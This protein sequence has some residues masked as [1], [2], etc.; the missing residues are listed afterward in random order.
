M[1]IHID[2]SSIESYRQFLSIKKLPS[3]AISGR[4]ASFPDEYAGRIGASASPV[5]HSYSPEP[6]LFDYQSAIAE[7]AIRKRKFA[8]FADCGLGKSLILL[9]YA[10]HVS[11]SHGKRCL[12]LTP[13]MVVRQLESE[14]RRF[15]GDS[16]HVETVSASR[17][18]EW[19][20]TAGP[21]VGITNYE[22]LKKTTEPGELGCLILDESSILKSHYGNYASICIKL[23][24]GLDWKLCLTGTPAPNDRI[25]YANHGVFLD[26]FPTI[27]SFLATYFIN[28][29][30]TQERWALKP[31]ALRPFYR[32]LSD[33]CIFLTN[34]AVYGWIDN[35][36]TIPPIRTHIHRVE[37]TKQQRDWI[38]GHLGSLVATRAGGI[39]T[40]G[41]YGQVAKGHWKGTDFETNKPGAIADL[42]NSWHGESTL[43]WCIYDR[44]QDLVHDAI[45]GESLSGKT[46]TQQRVDA[47][48]RFKSG[49]S[50]VLISKPRILG[51]GLNLQVATR[52]VFSGLQD[53]Y[54]SYYQCVKRSNRVGSTKPLDVHIPV[55]ELEE[56]MIE[57]VLQKADRVDAD[58]REQEALFKELSGL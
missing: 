11:Q 1:D 44:E 47:V 51:F 25:E 7:M 52:Q 34:P 6:F 36:G 13:P 2:T 39:Q 20:D 49:Y 29:G 8:V 22:A 57:T 3:Y 40:R 50:K 38:G 26:R 54:E 35:A 19:L 5:S 9:S 43:V 30:Q 37:L 17:L 27:N 18:Q 58:S 55:T 56:P 10:K 32:S 33:W 16:L 42:I 24:R 23:G 12:I 45:G 14:A 21:G 15:F 31:H 28:R 48:D 41:A 4:V 46:P 53:S